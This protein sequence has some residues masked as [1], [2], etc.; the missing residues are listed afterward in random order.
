MLDDPTIILLAFVT[1][2]SFP[3]SCVLHALESYE[4]QSLSGVAIMRLMFT[5]PLSD[6]RL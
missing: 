3:S 1:G 4:R 5:P 6:A 2:G